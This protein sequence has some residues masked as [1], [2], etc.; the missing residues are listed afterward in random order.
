[1]FFGIVALIGGAILILIAW[2]HSDEERRQRGRA[3]TN[4]ILTDF[5]GGSFGE[6]VSAMFGEWTHGCLS[7]VFGLLGIACI[8]FAFKS[9]SSDNSNNPDSSPAPVA[10]KEY[11]GREYIRECITKWDSCRLVAITKNGGNVA[12]A[13]QNSCAVCGAYP[14]KLWDALKEI[15]NDNH[16][17]TDVCLTDKGKWVVLFGKNEN[18]W[19]SDGLPLEM[20]D[21][22]WEFDRN[23]EKLLSVTVN[24]KDE[25]VVVSDKHFSSSSTEIQNWLVETMKEYGNLHSVT[26]TDDARVA[27]FEKGRSW[28]GNYPED[29]REATKKSTFHPYI[30]RMAGNSWFFADEIGRYRYSM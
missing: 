8:I 1:M 9:C 29:L 12:I 17:I 11:K 14:N 15:S 20:L 26:I 27:I 6:G 7:N 18:A 28:H 3:R 30:I 23:N 19:R 13:G 22:M 21:K 25:W 5:G 24:D 4:Q 10:K 16:M 2:G